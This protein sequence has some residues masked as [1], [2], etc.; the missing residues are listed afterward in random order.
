MAKNTKQNLN[1]K[2]SLKREKLK[3]Y[4]S[5]LQ[6]LRR[7]WIYNKIPHV[8]KAPFKLQWLRRTLFHHHTL[9]KQLTVWIRARPPL[10]SS[11][12][13]SYIPWTRGRDKALLSNHQN[14]IRNHPD[15]ANAS[16]GPGELH[17]EWREAEGH[18]FSEPFLETR[19]QPVLIRA[20]VNAFSLVWER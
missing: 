18:C 16:W 7:L 20:Q 19:S 12:A 6:R 3:Q 8:P 5:I 14:G 11:T 2:E 13:A 15:R 1:K 17:G 10:R 4:L 9:T